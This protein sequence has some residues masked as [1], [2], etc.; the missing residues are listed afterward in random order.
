MRKFYDY[1]CIHSLLLPFGENVI[2]WFSN[3][4]MLP[5]LQQSSCQQHTLNLKYGSRHIKSFLK[6][7]DQSSA[8]L[9]IISGVKLQILITT[10]NSLRSDRILKIKI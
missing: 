6:I 7:F 4:K 5:H 8:T 2:K 10:Y 3:H 1:N 9:K